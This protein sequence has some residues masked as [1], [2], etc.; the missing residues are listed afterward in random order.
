MHSALGEGTW[1]SSMGSQRPIC[2][3]FLLRTQR[4]QLLQ[5]W[6]KCSRGCP[7]KPEDSAWPREGPWQPP[8]AWVGTGSR[9]K[10]QLGQACRAVL[11]PSSQPHRCTLGSTVSGG[12]K[13]ISR[14][15]SQRKGFYLLCDLSIEGEGEHR[16]Q[17]EWEPFTAVVNATPWHTEPDACQHR[18]VGKQLRAHL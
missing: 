10:T 7:K 3:E 9:S 8:P 11:L 17:G 5:S 15:K 1:N 12:F 6:E 13:W 16:P 14:K 4:R 18:V 2:Q